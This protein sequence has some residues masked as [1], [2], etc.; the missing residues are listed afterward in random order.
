MNSTSSSHYLNNYPAVVS[1]DE[2]DSDYEYNEKELYSSS[3]GLYAANDN[4]SSKNNVSTTTTKLLLL[5]ENLLD[6]LVNR[7]AIATAAAE[8]TSTTTA[9]FTTDDNNISIDMSDIVDEYD[10]DDLNLMREG[11]SL[12]MDENEVIMADSYSNNSENND[13]KSGSPT[14]D[15]DNFDDRINNMF[16]ATDKDRVATTTTTT[17]TIGRYPSL[18]AQVTFDEDEDSSSS[19]CLPHSH[20]QVERYDENDLNLMREALIVIDD[21]DDEDEGIIMNSSNNNIISPTDY[22]NFLH[23]HT[24]NNNSSA[25]KAVDKYK[26]TTTA[27]TTTL[28]GGGYSTL[29]AHVTFE[30]DDNDN[31]L[32]RS[33]SQHQ[34]KPS[35]WLNEQLASY[36]DAFPRSSRGRKSSRKS[37][38][39]NNKRRTTTNNVANEATRHQHWSDQEDKL[40]KIEVKKQKFQGG[41]INWE[42]ISK[43]FGGT[44]APIQCKNRLNNYLQLGKVYGD[45]DQY[46]DVCILDMK[47]KGFMWA[48]IADRLQRRTGNHIRERFVN[49]LDPNIK[50]TPWTKDEDKIL[51]ANQRTLGNKWAEIQK[52]LPGPGI[53]PQN[54]IKNRFN[55]RVQ[56]NKRR[57]ARSQKQQNV[58]RLN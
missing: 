25:S 8:N 15:Y 9:T 20:Q 31:A 36:Y 50:K 28:F 4:A 47:R 17:T 34:V 57:L 45:W 46:E 7:D 1:F 39:N 42:V 38:K 56:A 54:S 29:L 16:D 58:F 44:R 3:A 49:Y 19:S 21:N 48:D 40:L 2:D 26:A 24:N 35:P 23:D 5:D 55:N 30:E 37:T 33:H 22:N 51:L 53:R 14:T 18:L 32:P 41:N 10:E 13:N 6:V 52:L 11:L 27:K 43:S 12:V